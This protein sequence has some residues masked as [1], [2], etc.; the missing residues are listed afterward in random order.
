L[1]SKIF[2]RYPQYRA[3]NKYNSQSLPKKFSDSDWNFVGALCLVRLFRKLSTM[4][5]SHDPDG[6]SLYTVKE[7]VGFYNNFTKREIRKFRQRSPGLGKLPEPGQGL[8]C[9]APESIRRCWVLAVDISNR[10][11]EL[12]SPRGCEEDFQGFVSFN[13]ES[14]SARTVSRAYPLPTS[15]S[16]SPRARRR[17]S[18]SSCWECSYASM[19]TITAAAR[20]LWVITRGSLEAVTRFIRDVASCR[21]SVMGIMLGILAIGNTSYDSVNNT[22]N[23]SKNQA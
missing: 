15:I 21:R 22:T 1:F 10:G 23:H 17:K 11:K 6:F 3:P 2:S 7:A 14:A 13:K 16:L 5:D 12:L 9:F 20:P 8:F 18:S 4:P 19:L